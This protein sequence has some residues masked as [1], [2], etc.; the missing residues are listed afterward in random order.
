MTDSR[1]LLAH[2]LARRA[3]VRLAA[4]SAGGSLLA[5]CTAAPPASPTAAPP[6]SL[7]ASKPTAAPAAPTTAAPPAAAVPT[8]AAPAAANP[9][10]GK[11]LLVSSYGGVWDDAVKA[12]AVDPLKQ[13]Y[14]GLDFSI[15]PSGGF[16]KLL[17]Q[18]DNPEADVSFIDDSTLAQAAQ[19]GLAQKLDM[20]RI[21]HAADLY[22]QAK[23]FGDYGVAVEF[24]RL[25]LAYRTDKISKPVTSWNDLWDPDYKGHVAVGAPT[26][27]GTAWVQFLVAA[28][29][30]NGG[31][32][33]N[34]EPGF[35]KLEQLKQ[36]LLTI[37]E[38]NAA[39]QTQLLQSGDLWIT[40]FWDGRTIAL[41][42]Q[43]VSVEFITPKE[44]AFGTITYIAMIK[45]S[46]LTDLDH[47][48]INL[49]ISPEGQVAFGKYIGYGPT[50]A[51][52]KL[53]DE[54]L[55][56]GVL[57]GKEQVDRMRVLDWDKLLP[58][59]PEWLDRWNSIMRG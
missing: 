52:A 42:R 21:P 17:A 3:F 20:A 33:D 39:Q 55:K 18:K 10:A 54:Y 12:A 22:P 45:G 57:Y 15:D 8:Q 31:S 16:T 1:R 32:V 30:L 23:L 5:A 28:A 46:Q 34:V 48:F 53:P 2:A 37:T 35:Q 36:Q 25:G 14:P 6:T 27:G 58:K 4:M 50:N 26:A 44:G 19:I 13:K 51:K 59:R 29:E 49:M 41:K 11:T 40:H 47:E 7:P 56:E 38:T 24:G 43:G 9:Y